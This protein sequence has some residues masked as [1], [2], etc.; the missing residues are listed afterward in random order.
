MGGFSYVYER[1]DMDSRYQSVFSILIILHSL[2]SSKKG[3]ELFCSENRKCSSL[4][5]ILWY[6]YI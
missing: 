4:F 1:A 2:F 5:D 6:I 3:F